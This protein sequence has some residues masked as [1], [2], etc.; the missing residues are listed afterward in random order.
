M[1]G[2]RLPRCR[3]CGR[4][5]RPDRYNV[6]R[7]EWCSRD[8]CRLARDRARKRR[9]HRKKLEE[10]AAFRESE[11]RRCRKAMRALRAR[12]RREASEPE[13]DPSA[14]VPEI[15]ELVVGLVSHLA[16]TI[17]PEALAEVM[18]RYAERGRRLAVGV[19]GRAPP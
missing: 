4:A 19:A 1:A 15:P 16:D 17:D 2:K 9:H 14:V 13:S 3:Q 10:D 5:F 8:A 11:R 7:Q 12:R 6:D 18:D